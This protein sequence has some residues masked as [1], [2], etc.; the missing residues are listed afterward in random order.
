M[1]V[2]NKN[3]KRADNGVA[4][5]HGVAKKMAE[6]YKNNEDPLDIVI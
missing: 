1:E 6:D 4:F 5:D 3:D 2:V